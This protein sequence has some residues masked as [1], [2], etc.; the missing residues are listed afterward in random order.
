MP[1]PQWEVR[2]VSQGL[3]TPDKDLGRHEGMCTPIFP[4]TE[5]PQGRE[6]LRANKEFP[7]KNCYHH[8][9]P[10]GTS[11]AVSSVS[12]EGA[13][14]IALPDEEVSRLFRTFLTD[15]YSR[16]AREPSSESV[17]QSIDK[18]N[19]ISDP[20]EKNSARPASPSPAI[21]MAQPPTNS[22]SHEISSLTRD[23]NEI[24]DDAELYEDFSDGTSIIESSLSHDS[25]CSDGNE[26][27]IRDPFC[28]Y[29][30]MDVW[31]DLSVF[32]SQPIPS[33]E[34]FEAEAQEISK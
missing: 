34:D 16:R 3:P 31:L 4:T 13:S 23:P 21:P 25:D 8:S 5:H 26:A 30:T 20:G 24:Y 11:L 12:S 22:E 27:F 2:I 9:L 17:P 14:G 18:D 10:G 7:W 1:K 28:I 15:S 29:P 33:L 6:P 32:D 19:S